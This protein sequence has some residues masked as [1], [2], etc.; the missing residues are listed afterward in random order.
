MMK[1]CADIS[2][3]G[4]LMKCW[5]DDDAISRLEGVDR[6]IAGVGTARERHRYGILSFK[7]MESTT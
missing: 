5:N 6:R 4:N 2:V 7:G 1:F 3:E